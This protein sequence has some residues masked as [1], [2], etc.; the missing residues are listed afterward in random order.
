MVIN[1]GR[2]V[3]ISVMG[4]LV[5]S[6]LHSWHPCI[7]KI[8]VCVFLFGFA[9]SR[10]PHPSLQIKPPYFSHILSRILAQPPP[11]FSATTIFNLYTCLQGCFVINAG[12]K[13]IVLCYIQCATIRFGQNKIFDRLNIKCKK[14]K[15]KDPCSNKKNLSHFLKIETYWNLK[16]FYR[17]KIFNIT[18]YKQWF[19]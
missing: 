10:G 11:L 17:K 13:H 14:H 18:D 1:P 8:Y 3:E 12:D 6:L 7:D 16:G 15:H 4:W 9:H 19:F 2:N 5:P